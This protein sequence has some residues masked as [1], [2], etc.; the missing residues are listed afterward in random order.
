[1]SAGVCSL[2]TVGSLV[3]AGTEDGLVLVWQADQEV[4]ISQNRAHSDRVSCL[5]QV[6]NHVWSGSGDRI[7]VAHDVHSYQVLYSLNDQGD[8]CSTILCCYTDGRPNMPYML[9]HLC[10]LTEL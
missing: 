4:L 9:S 5:E 7:I 8:C 2:R 3:W 10:M 1:M 6:G